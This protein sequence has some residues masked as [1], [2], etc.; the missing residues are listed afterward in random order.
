M[1]CDDKLMRR[2]CLGLFGRRLA[3]HN[4]AICKAPDQHVATEMESRELCRIFD[5]NGMP[6]ARARQAATSRSV[7]EN[8]SD[9]QGLSAAA[10]CALPNW[11]P[12]ETPT[13]NY[14]SSISPTPPFLSTTTYHPIPSSHQSSAMLSRALRTSA[15]APLRRVYAAPVV[16][17]RSVTTDAASSHVDPSAVPAV[18]WNHCL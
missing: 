15:A 18:S 3:S 10:S 4:A 9:N 12:P 2:E 16:A 13:E 5:G 17:R 1:G 11:I 7:S 8:R 14:L 6:N